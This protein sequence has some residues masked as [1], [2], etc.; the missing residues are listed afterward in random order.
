MFVYFVIMNP[1]NYNALNCVF[2]IFGKLSTRR[3]ALA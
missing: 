3:G 1:P 2:N